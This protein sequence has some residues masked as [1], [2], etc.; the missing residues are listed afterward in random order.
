VVDVVKDAPGK[1]AAFDKTYLV[2][3]TDGILNIGFA[4]G[5]GASLDPMISAIEVK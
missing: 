5:T 2:T 3:V 4:R 1:A